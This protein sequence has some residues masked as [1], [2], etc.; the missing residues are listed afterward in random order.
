M[1]VLASFE[2]LVMVACLAS[3]LL[4]RQGEGTRGRETE[5]KG[6]ETQ[7]KGRGCTG[8]RKDRLLVKGKKSR[9]WMT[10]GR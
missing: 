9:Y 3:G 2:S 7:T 8:E 6:G 4:D 5:T 1:E 10:V